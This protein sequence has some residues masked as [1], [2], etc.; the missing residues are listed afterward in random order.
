[1][2]A[3]TLTLVAVL[4][5]STA[6]AQEYHAA[7]PAYGEPQPAVIQVGVGFGVGQPPCGPRPAAVSQ[8]G[9][10]ELRTTQQYVPGAVQQVYVPGRCSYR[11]H[12]QFC[13]AGRY[14]TQ[15]LPGHYESRQ[16]WVWVAQGRFDSGYAN[17]G[18]GY[19]RYRHGR[20]GF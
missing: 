15:Q 6:L 20:R 1:M 10:W 16:E 2:N 11:H 8:H 4:A 18:Y 5:G 19:G 13:E 14:V 7:S 17:A 3:H 12:R 9:R